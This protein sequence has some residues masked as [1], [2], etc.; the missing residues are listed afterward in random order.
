MLSWK[1][2]D[3]KILKYL[4]SIRKASGQECILVQGHLLDLGHK[5]RSAF[6]EVMRSGVQG[7]REVSNKRELRL[8]IVVIFLSC[9]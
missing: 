1:N 5:L 8:G 3:W 7:H 4:G 9:F 6:Q 2:Q